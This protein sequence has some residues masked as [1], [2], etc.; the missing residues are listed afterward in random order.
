MIVNR[1]DFQRLCLFSSESEQTIIHTI[2]VLPVLACLGRWSP[3]GTMPLA[4][5]PRAEDKSAGRSLSLK[6]LTSCQHSPDNSACHS[7]PLGF[8]QSARVTESVRRSPSPS[9]VCGQ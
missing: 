9:F 4:V 7:N 8:Q 6:D 5:A 3:A 2:E 1:L